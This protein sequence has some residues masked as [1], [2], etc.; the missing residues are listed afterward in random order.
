ML[1]GGFIAR[2]T[3]RNVGAVNSAFRVFG[4]RPGAQQIMRSRFAGLSII[5]ARMDEDGTVQLHIEIRAWG[6]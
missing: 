2:T 5:A 6:A 3:T 4:V 1:G